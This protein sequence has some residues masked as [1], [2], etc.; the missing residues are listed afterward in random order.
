MHTAVMEVQLTEG[1]LLVRTYR[2][3][4]ADALYEAVRE[5]IAEVSVWLP[6]CH[7]NYSIEESREFVSSRAQAAQADEW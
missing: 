5:S 2:A 7:E 6:W 4:D 1:P 3:E